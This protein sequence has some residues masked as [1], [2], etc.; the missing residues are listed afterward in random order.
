MRHHVFD[1][2]S[3]SATTVIT[4]S[5]FKKTNALTSW[6]IDFSFRLTDSATTSSNYSTDLRM[7]L[8]ETSSY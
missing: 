2:T 1:M 6:I 7:Y 3:D 8:L 5:N 4:T